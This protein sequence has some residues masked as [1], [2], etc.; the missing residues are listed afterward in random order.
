MAA[1][2]AATAGPVYLSAA[3]Q[4]VL[5]HVIVPLGPESTGLVANELPG[6]PVSEATFVRAFTQ[7]AHSSSGRYFERPIYTAIASAN[8]LAPSGTVVAVADVVSR[9]EDCAKLVFVA[10]QCPSKPGTVA[11]SRRSA[12]FLHV[13]LGT[14][15]VAS[16]ANSTRH[17]KVSGLYAAQSASSSYWWGQDYFEFG[18]SQ[19]Q[20]PRLDALFAS[21]RM[22]DALPAQQVALSADVA[23]ATKSLKSA[24]L[25]A[26]RHA[27][28]SE[29]LRLGRLDLLASSGIGSYLDNVA[30]QQQAMTTTIAVIDLQLLLLVLMVLFGIAGRIVAEREQDLALANLRGLSPRSLWAVALREPVV[31]V[32]AAAPLGAVLGWTVALLTART[33][34]LANTPVPFD[35][36]ALA[37]AVVAALAALVATAAGSR[38][39][40]ARS[41]RTAPAGR[42]RIGTALTLAGEAFVIALALA[43]VVQV[44]ASG[45]G[46]TARSQPLAALAPGLV[47]LAA[48]VIAARA[49]PF[50]CR[51]MA[52]LMRFSPR[53]GLCLALQRVARQRGVIRQAV[54]VAI[55]VSLACF[56]VA[57]FS[58]DRSN[59]AEQAAFLVGA[60]RV[61]TV[62]VPDTVDFVQ[63]VRRADPSRTKAMAVEVESS[64]Q[65]TLLAIDASRFAAVAAWAGQRGAARPAAVARYLAP[66]VAPEITVEGASL[67]M[68]VDLRAPISPRPSLVV[69]VFNEQYGATG[70]V[71]IGPLETG[72]HSYATSLEGYC[73]SVCR[74]QSITA[75]WSGPPAGDAT[76]AVVIPVTIEQIRDAGSSLVQA[77]LSHPGSWRVTQDPPGVASSLSYSGLGMVASFRYVAGQ[78]PPVIAPADVPPLL[79]AVVTNVVAGVQASGPTGSTDYSVLNLDGSPL[80]VDGAMQVAAIPS[81]G[82]NAVMVDLTDA[83]RDESLPDIYST[84]QVWLSAAAGS[85]AAIIARLGRYGIRVL[86]VSSARS[87]ELGFQ[88]D[89]PT[90][91]FELFLVVGA[92]SALLA[93]G[94]MLF[95]IAADTRKRAVEAVALA[96]VGLPRRSLVAAMAGELGIV[97]ATGLIAGAAAGIAAAHFSLPSVPEF[98]GLAQ[99]PA[100][101]FDLPVVWLAEVLGGA[102]VLMALVVAVSISVVRAASTPDKLRISQR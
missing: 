59:R 52:T 54:V 89:G 6:H 41:T 34:L 45:V 40:L 68:T 31:L 51:L 8:L 95:A 23:V 64:S 13:K 12:A 93:T 35:S 96:A 30:T 46:S 71:T 79:P 91:A 5:A 102:A 32:I 65:G 37:A 81:V 94:S 4:S 90:L 61:L 50:A 86:K 42:S 85:G 76:G 97:C 16:L 48:G 47:A 101:V 75:S 62:S 87:V 67:A 74:L 9:S 77:G 18:T 26:F 36:L 58:V 24:E 63:A 60:N 57:G 14:V 56:A 21:P 84:K 44:S 25:P 33:E 20:P 66:S 100:L 27:L 49:V 82:N 72:K 92:E 22:L 78:A 39:T 69:G 43:A 88:Q 15:L 38:R 70:S 3:D 99:G 29:E 73:V 19:T 2:A 1:V 11:I 28:S 98:T 17:L 83:L 55:A 80:S 53:V 10:G 7:L